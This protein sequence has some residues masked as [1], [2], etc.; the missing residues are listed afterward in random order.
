MEVDWQ[1]ADGQLYAGRD[2]LE[3]K[4]LGFGTLV[5]ERRYHVLQ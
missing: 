3:E 2:G 4:A 5:C 1:Q